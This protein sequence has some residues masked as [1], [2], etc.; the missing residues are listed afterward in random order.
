MK[1][2]LSPELPDRPD[3]I[4]AAITAA[5]QVELGAQGMTGDRFSRRVLERVLT[6]HDSIGSAIEGDDLEFLL[7]RISQ[8]VH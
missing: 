2:I 1:P 8:T 4:R 7:G 3:P 5:T 6:Q